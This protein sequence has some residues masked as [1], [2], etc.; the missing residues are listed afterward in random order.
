[1]KLIL[2]D[3]DG[4][5]IDSGNT[6]TDTINFV[7]NA[8]GLPPI[9]KEEM[10][11]A[12]NDPTIHSSQFFYGTDHFTQ[13]QSELFHSFYEEHCVSD[14]R[15]YDGILAILEDFHCDTILG[16]A[17][18]ANSHF[19]NK[20]LR[21]LGIAHYFSIVVGADMVERPKPHGE[22]ITYAAKKVGATPRSTL[23]VGDSLKDLQAAKNSNADGILVNWGFTKHTVDLEVIDTPQALHQ[24]LKKRIQNGE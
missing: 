13:E 4:T 16:V 18:N 14:I 21:H 12:L 15:L 8:L 24:E 19:A 6:I 22:M 9:A 5:L 23:L 17:T 20:M 11:H 3:M 2:F 1:M 10:L 7:R